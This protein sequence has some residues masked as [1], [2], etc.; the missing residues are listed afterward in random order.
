MKS[1]DQYI[2][3]LG[4]VQASIVNQSV[5]KLLAEHNLNPE[6]LQGHKLL[7]E[8]RGDEEHA[9][10]YKPIGKGRIRREISPHCHFIFYQYAELWTTHVFATC[11]VH[12][13][14]LNNLRNF[15]VSCFYVFHED[16]VPLK[17]MSRW[18]LFQ[19]LGDLL[20]GIVFRYIPKVSSSV[21]IEEDHLL[22]STPRARLVT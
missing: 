3:H 16:I 8:K 17:A 5:N 15:F 9:I 14:G 11:S 21:T 6:N 1:F 7:I 13:S 22:R 10:L 18:S 4:Y 2:E 19:L 12:P 20:L